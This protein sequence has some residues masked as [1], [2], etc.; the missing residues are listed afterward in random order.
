MMENSILNKTE[1]IQIK[2]LPGS[3]VLQQTD[4][5][6]WIDLY[7]YKDETFHRGEFKL[8]SLGVA[9]KLPDGY[10]AIVAPR[11]S[12]YKRYGLAQTNSIGV[13]DNSYA[14]EDDIWMFPAKADKDIVIPK[15]TRL[16]Q[17]RICKIQPKLIFEKVEH[18]S[19]ES[20]GGFGSTG[21]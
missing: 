16:C 4:K 21:M 5:G 19:N 20:R 8:I 15:G 11:S 17:F 12:T 2:Y 1:T 10:E 3:P 13:I 7:T 14:G 18:L 9:M 6:D